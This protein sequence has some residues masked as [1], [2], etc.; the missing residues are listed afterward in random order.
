MNIF[1]RAQEVPEKSNESDS[2]PGLKNLI[3]C[4]FDQDSSFISED[5]DE[6]VA[7]FK[8]ENQPAFTQNIINVKDDIDRFL[9]V[10]GENDAQLSEAFTR[11]FKPETA[12]SGWNGRTMREALMKI[13]EILS[14]DEIPAPASK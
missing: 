12:I 1:G 4:Y 8:E 9:K 2:Y 5:P 10:Y 6:V 7:Y 13:V 3:G 14:D 11:V